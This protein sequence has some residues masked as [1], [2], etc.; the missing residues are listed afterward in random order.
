MKIIP[1]ID[2][3]NGKCVRLYQGRADQETIYSEDPVSVAR[4]WEE[5]GAELIHIVDLDGAF[6]GGLKNFTLI[7]E[8]VKAVRIPIEIGGGIRDMESIRRYID[9]G[10]GF[11]ILGTAAHNNRELVQEACGIFP[12]KIIVGS[13]SKDGLVAVRGWEV[14]TEEDALSMA[15]RMEECGIAAIIYTDISRDGTLVGPNFGSIKN[16]AQ[17][18]A[19]PVIASGGVSAKKDIE[20]LLELEEYGVTGVIVGKALYSGAV[21]LPELIEI[22]GNK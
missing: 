7:S 12:G 20:G 8:M 19:I 6:E 11:V 5:D 17:S 2:I 13:D 4:K 22:T 21:T 1:A 3:R 16:L 15:K 14:V 10:A 18:I 9:T